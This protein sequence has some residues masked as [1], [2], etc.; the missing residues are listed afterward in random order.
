MEL[1]L[2]KLQ[3]KI[4]MIKVGG[5]TETEVKEMKFRV[6]DA[7]HATRAAKE[8]G[9]VPGGATTLARISLDMTIDPGLDEGELEGAKVVYESLVEPF[10]Q[11]MTNAGEDGG[12]RL[13]Q[14]LK[15]TEG[16]GFDVKK[17]TDEPIMLADI[18]DPTAVI[19]SVVENAC[20][21]AGVT[22][23]IPL[24]ITINRQWQLDEVS[25]TRARQ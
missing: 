12:Y 24:T 4:G 7:V 2:A 11:L 18:L 15:E 1:R 8:N 22:I 14:I 9:I 25:M 21:F 5:S 20:S 13:S 10:K 6:E 16:F 19:K 23:T 3:G 17:I